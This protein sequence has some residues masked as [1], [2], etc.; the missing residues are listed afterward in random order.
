LIYEFEKYALNDA[1]VLVGEKITGTSV[2]TVYFFHVTFFGACMAYAGDA[3][4]SN[5]HG[6]L[7]IKVTPKSE[8]GKNKSTGHT[9]ISMLSDE[10]VLQPIYQRI[11]F[12][13]AD[14]PI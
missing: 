1:V 4:E 11:C 14:Q 7:C 2:L 12:S 10:C 6:I 8:S 9:K 5:R 13:P 3:E